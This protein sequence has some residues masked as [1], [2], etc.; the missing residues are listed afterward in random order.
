MLLGKK[1]ATRMG[2]LG[3]SPSTYPAGITSELIIV[4]PLGVIL[5]SQR[6]TL[7]P[8]IRFF[9]WGPFNPI[10]TPNIAAESKIKGVLT[11]MTVLYFSIWVQPIKQIWE[12][13]SIGT[14]SELKEPQNKKVGCYTSEPLNGGN[15]T[16]FY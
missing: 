8:L 14:C 13:P 9:F 11:C 15:S 6:N 7:M 2:S 1:E 10:V 16:G 5:L 12:Y 3:K 4:P